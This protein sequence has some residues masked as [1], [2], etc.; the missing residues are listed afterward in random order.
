MHD[1]LRRTTV[2]N[3]LDNLYS[4]AKRLREKPQLT[5]FR[6]VSPIFIDGFE[7]SL[8]THSCKSNTLVRALLEG[9][10]SIKSASVSPPDC[11]DVTKVW[12]TLNSD[13][14]ALS[15][16]GFKV[17]SRSLKELDSSKLLRECELV[18]VDTT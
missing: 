17:I 4:V 7:N 13:S 10:D 9:L 5:G 14:K 6:W 18:K 1:F 12:V 3:E 2:E 8:Q 15:D 16:G 11:A